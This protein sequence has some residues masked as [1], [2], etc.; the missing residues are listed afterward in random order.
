MNTADYPSLL[1]SS[2]KVRSIKQ[3]LKVLGPEF[4]NNVM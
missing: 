4:G 3:T 2:A 1:Q